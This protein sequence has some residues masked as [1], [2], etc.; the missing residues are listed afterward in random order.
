MSPGIEIVNLTGKGISKPESRQAAKWIAKAF[1]YAP[2]PPALTIFFGAVPYEN[3]VELHETFW[4]SHINR[5]AHHGILLGAERSEDR[6]VARLQM[7]L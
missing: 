5:C 4:A 1:E 6:G 2:A 7:L 3:N